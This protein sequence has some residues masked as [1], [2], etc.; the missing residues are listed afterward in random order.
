MLSGMRLLVG[1]FSILD[2]RIEVSQRIYDYARDQI[3]K[4]CEGRG[5]SMSEQFTDYLM[6]ANEV[7]AYLM[8]NA[9]SVLSPVDQKVGIDNLSKNI[10]AVLQ[11]I[12]DKELKPV[13]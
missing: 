5:G 7:S 12:A 1:R 4:Y 10:E 3:A 6:I 11:Y 9:L 8:G 13:N 2:K